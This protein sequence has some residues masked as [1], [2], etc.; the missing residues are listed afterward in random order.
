[1]WT[2]E[3]VNPGPLIQEA[4][5]LTISLNTYP[6]VV[7]LMTLHKSFWHLQFFHLVIFLGQDPIQGPPLHFATWL[8]WHLQYWLVPCPALLFVSLGLL[9]SHGKLSQNIPHCKDIA[10]VTD[11]SHMCVCS[12]VMWILFTGTIILPLVTTVSVEFLRNQV[13]ISSLL[14]NIQGEIFWDSAKILFPLN[15]SMI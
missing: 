4:G 13:A 3:P 6:T 1:M 11:S 15:S 8:L 12:K 7:P 5:I 10:E 14:M 9:K 2:C